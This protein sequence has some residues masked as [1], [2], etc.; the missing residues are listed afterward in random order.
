MSSSEQ[1]A[2][3]RGTVRLNA[4]EQQAAFLEAIAE[5]DKA[6]DADQVYSA[7]MMYRDW[8]EEQGWYEAAKQYDAFLLAPERERSRWPVIGEAGIERWA[9]D[10]TEH[11]REQYQLATRRSLGILTGQPGSGK[12]FLTARLIRALLSRPFNR[13][14]GRVG[15]VAPTGKAAVRITSY[16]REIGVERGIVDPST[17][18][19][20]LVIG[21]NGHDGKGWGFNRDRDNPLEFGWLICD[22]SSMLET[23]LAHSLLRACR[24]GTHVLLVGDPFQ[25]PPVGHGFPLRDLIAAGVPH[26][27]LTE[28]Q[29]NAGTVVRQCAAIR[30]KEL[31]TPDAKLDLP[32]HNLVHKELAAPGDVIEQVCELVR[33][34]T[35]PA[36]PSGRYGFNM[37]EVQVIAPLN[38]KSAVSR[39]AIN[40]AIMQMLFGRKFGPREFVPGMKVICLVNGYHMRRGYTGATNE[41]V[42]NGDMGQ[43]VEVLG[44]GT[45][46]VAFR[47]PPREVEFMVSEGEEK[48]NLTAAYAI[49]GHKSQG[50]QWPVVIIVADQFGGRVAGR[51][52]WYTAISRA[53]RFAVTV[54]KLGVIRRQCGVDITERRKTFLRELLAET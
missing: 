41:Y 6:G 12:T 7:T 15:V 21:R 42:A 54:G 52:W 1:A 11:Q 51:S 9:D 37:D 22:E 48:L 28:I 18:H 46:A 50:A 26:G 23:T 25:L 34:F 36:D 32:E 3:S 44:R 20:A 49:T 53:Q 35:D 16:L 27:Q 24:S 4:H 14:G 38:S 13:R 8:L 5:A 40:S 17:I 29:R 33:G 19:S 2:K 30:R 43:V 45:V 31:F 47:D 10:L 39:E